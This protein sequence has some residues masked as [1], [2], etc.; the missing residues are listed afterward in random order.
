MKR[1]LVRWTGYRSPLGPH[2][3]AFLAAKRALG[4][5]FAIEERTLRLLD[6]FVA[7]KAL[8]SLGDVTPAVVDEFLASRPRKSAR[9]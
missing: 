7:S 3:H 8:A 4:M 5:R 1:V 6:R 2:I 9:S